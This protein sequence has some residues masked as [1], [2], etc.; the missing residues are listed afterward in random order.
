MYKKGTKFATFAILT[1]WLLFGHCFAS[2]NILYGQ[3]SGAEPF[4][5]RLG[6]EKQVFYSSE[7]H[8]LIYRSSV[9]AE[10]L[11][12]VKM[13][14]VESLHKQIIELLSG[15]SSKEPDAIHLHLDHKHDESNKFIALFD[16]LQRYAEMHKL[17]VTVREDSNQSPAQYPPIERTSIIEVMIGQPDQ[18]EKF[19]NYAAAAYHSYMKIN[20]IDF[21]NACLFIHPQYTP[22]ESNPIDQYLYHYQHAI[23]LSNPNSCAVSYNYATNLRDRLVDMKVRPFSAN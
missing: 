7:K 9:E 13:E 5:E 15:V 6:I 19:I 4:A 16:D 1:A 8:P 10:S 21:D 22:D 11:T 20:H 23:M 14:E 17:T 18:M 12:T 2:D 3:S